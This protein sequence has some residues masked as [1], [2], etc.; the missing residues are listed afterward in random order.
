MG[1][2]NFDRKPYQIDYHERIWG[3]PIHDD[4]QHFEFICFEVMQGGLS[5]WL[6]YGKRE[7]FIK[8]FD[9]FDFNKV[10][11]YSEN[12]IQRIMNVD[13]MIKSKIKIEAIINNAK[14]F[15]EIAKEF[16][17]FD[18][19][20]WRFSEGKTIIYDKHPEGYIPSS[21][22]LSL[23]ISKDLKKRGLKYLG[24]IV[25][26]SHMQACGMIL[27]HDKNCPCYTEIMSKYPTIQ[28]RRYL[29]KDIKYYGKKEKKH[30]T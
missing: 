13:G 6:V 14:C 21:N 18:N 4:R 12:D 8:C 24:A 9:S 1:Y 25:V 30:G 2:C 19:Y 20:L 27:D 10:A 23:R 17:S 26:Y 5:W 29:E 16:G 28:K 22:G 15:L 3:R 11:Q 7:I